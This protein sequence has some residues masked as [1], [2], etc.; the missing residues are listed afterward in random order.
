[1]KH[2]IGVIHWAASETCNLK[3]SYC[4]LNTDFKTQKPDNAKALQAFVQFTNKLDEEGLLPLEIQFIGAEP[5][6]ISNY[7][8]RHMIDYY[9]NTNGVN[10]TKFRFQT[11][12]Q[13]SNDYFDIFKPDEVN[14]VISLDVCEEQNDKNRGKG[15]YRKAIDNALALRSKGFTVAII[16]VLSL[17]L[18]RDIESL[19]THIAFC[20][21]HGVFTTFKTIHTDNPE[22]SLF[23]QEAYDLG[24]VLVEHGIHIHTQVMR[25]NMCMNFGNNCSV[26]EMTNDGRVYNCNKVYNPKITVGDWKKTYI[27]DVLT[28]RQLF[29]NNR[30]IN[31]KCDA[32]PYFKVCNAGCPV[33]R[34]DG[35]SHECYFKRGIYDTL[36]EQSGLPIEKHLMNK[37]LK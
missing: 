19:K 17:P 12:G 11:N 28:N 35:L 13:F 29:F 7:I 9:V 10:A 2:R 4:Y 3:C 16:S 15:T 8:Y 18:L 26:I 6:V 31:P 22:L 14:V 1:M 33:D 5:T 30:Y 34:R 36:V 37:V 23:C 32:C 25:S 24:K 20:K 27:S 21:E